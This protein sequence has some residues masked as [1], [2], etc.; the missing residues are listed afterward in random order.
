M[1]RA[2]T[3]VLVVLG[4]A[5]ACGPSFETECRKGSVAFCDLVYRCPA[6]SA[7]G[8]MFLASYGPTKQDCLNKSNASCAMGCPRSFDSSAGAACTAAYE[9]ASCDDVWPQ[10]APAICLTV[11]K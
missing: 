1:K 2:L 4:L 5:V 6:T 3:V 7:I 11:C 9:S 8:S 10:R